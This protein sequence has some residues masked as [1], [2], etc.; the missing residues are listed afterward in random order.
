[1]TKQSKLTSPEQL[2]IADFERLFSLFPLSELN[3]KRLF[4]T[5]GTGFIGFWLLM[6]IS[7][8]NMTGANIT[9]VALSRDPDRFLS[10]HPFFKQCEWL[11]FCQGDVTDY[12]YPIG[13]FDL[14]IH[15][16]TDTSPSAIASSLQLFQSMVNGTA[17]V[18][19]H[20]ASS[21]AQRV[22]IISSGAVYGEQPQHIEKITEGASY[23]GSSL[24]LKN[25]YS[26]GK[27]AME[28]LSACYAQGHDIEIVTAR[29]FAFLGYGLPEH[30]AIGQ[31][32]NDAIYAD[33]IT[34]K[35][36]G[37]PVR[38]YLYAADL[39]VWLL[40]ILMRGH[41]GTAYNVGSDIGM[42]IADI[43]L[44]V[45]AILSP[46]KNIVIKDSV[47]QLNSVRSTYIPD[48]EKARQELGLDVWT[49]LSE[50]IRKHC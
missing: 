38:S 9:V 32:I 3:G 30:L 45:K 43:S 24:D 26:E 10:S 35:G 16:A 17:H 34:I 2:A 49:S 25:V 39:V 48:I 11:S 42:T 27:R 41:S 50:A 28:M 44:K 6:A 36:N 19:N 8:L 37:K 20:A 47:E 13:N 46:R 7:Y 12:L 14:F 4:I 33:E 1:M 31:F 21:N 23:A 15:G 29:C 18:L 5:G 40:A 22:L